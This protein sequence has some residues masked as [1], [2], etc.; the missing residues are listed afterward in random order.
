MSMKALT[1]LALHSIKLE[2][3]S[4]KIVEL[5]ILRHTVKT[6]LTLL[7]VIENRV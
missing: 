2:L 7:K 1:V 6:T 4:H 3:S 5:G